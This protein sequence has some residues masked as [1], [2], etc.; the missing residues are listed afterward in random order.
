MLPTRLNI[1]SEEK[2]EY[3]QK[4]FY[5]QFI[6]GVLE[7][8]L[9]VVAV[10][11]M[12]LV[13]GQRILETHFENLVSQLTNNTNQYSHKNIEI[14]EINNTLRE[15]EKIQAEHR[16]WS[17]LLPEF[18]NAIPPGISL[19]TVIFDPNNNRYTIVGKA[20]TRDS[21]LSLQKSLEETPVVVSLDIPL[22]RLTER[23]NIDFSIVAVTQ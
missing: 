18:F 15:A 19:T 10:C 14:K 13:G 6:K 5:F 21:L 23:E 4:M 12:F 20:N 11:A 8:M 3:L 7:Q 9:F 22:S 17:P 2:K 16:Y 1:I